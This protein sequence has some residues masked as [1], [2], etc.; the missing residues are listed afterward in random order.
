MLTKDRYYAI[1]G[2][3]SSKDNHD[4]YA[5]IIELFSAEDNFKL[6]DKNYYYGE[7]VQAR[8][9]YDWREDDR[10]WREL[11]GAKSMRKTTYDIMMETFAMKITFLLE[12]E[13]KKMKLRLLM[14]WVMVIGGIIGM[15]TVFFMGGDSKDKEIRVM[16]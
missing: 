8:N 3:I 9:R 14:I 16:L 15:A 2:A 1:L 7:G 5:T 10:L 6:A 11:T 4:L 13:R 12:E